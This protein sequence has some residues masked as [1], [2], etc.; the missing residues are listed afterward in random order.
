MKV[1]PVC[2]KNVCVRTARASLPVLVADSEDL[3]HAV[4]HGFGKPAELLTLLF[5]V[6]TTGGLIYSQTPLM[7]FETCF[8]CL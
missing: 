5:P 3:L 6:K 1:W 7:L 4:V 2:G 8:F